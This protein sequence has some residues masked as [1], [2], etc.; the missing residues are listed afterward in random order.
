M[1]LFGR[2][3]SVFSS[4]QSTETSQAYNSDNS[5]SKSDYD[6]LVTAYNDLDGHYK[7]ANERLQ[8]YIRRHESETNKIKQLEASISHQSGEAQAAREKIVAM[9]AQVK[10]L[11]SQIYSMATGRGPEYDDE[12][13]A[14]QF[15]KLKC[16]VE[17][18]MLK[19]S[20][21]HKGQ[22]LSDEIPSRLL[23]E[24]GRLGD[25][26]ESSCSFLAN[27]AYSIQLMY[28]T[29]GILRHPLLRHIVALFLYRFVFRPF[30][31]GLSDPV[32][33]AFKS[34]NK[35]VLAKGTHHFEE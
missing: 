21:A 2:V 32:S 12:H 22:V 24:L 4:P 23:E 31:V 11:R 5:Q 3:A 14:G 29:Q 15:D 30:A 1:S 27:R 6:T 9:E 33:R 25:I 20:R 7:R 8:R 34:V 16:L 26:G 19:L 18:E 28:I 35:Y 13:Y 17:T 10:E